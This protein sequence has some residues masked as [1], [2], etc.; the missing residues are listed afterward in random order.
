MLCKMLLE[1]NLKNFPYRQS[2]AL[3]PNTPQTLDLKV[4][5]LPPEITI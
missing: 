1:R 4:K 3:L 5:S 2:K